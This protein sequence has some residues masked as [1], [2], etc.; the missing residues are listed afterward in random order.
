MKFTKVHR[1]S[2]IQGH[3]V[4]ADFDVD[5]FVLLLFCSYWSIK[6]IFLA[7]LPE[8]LTFQKSYSGLLCDFGGGGNLQEYTGQDS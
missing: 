8:T 3:G 6:L 5:H 7:I 4:E 1:S 2:L